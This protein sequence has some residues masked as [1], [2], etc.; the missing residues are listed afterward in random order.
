M[1]HHAFDALIIFLAFMCRYFVG[2]YKVGI[3][4]FLSPR[5]SVV[6]FYTP[7][8]DY[9]CVLNFFATKNFVLAFVFSQVL[10][11]VLCLVSL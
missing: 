8:F 5:Q 7:N 9:L 6:F 11:V 10:C 4:S 3:V 1:S 2:P